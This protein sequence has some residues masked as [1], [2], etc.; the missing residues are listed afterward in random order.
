[1]RKIVTVFGSSIPVEGEEQY[2]IAYRLGAILAKNNF[3]VCNGGN[4]GIMEA[5]SRGA[6]ENGGKAIGIT[7]D[8]YFNSHNKYLTEHIICKT[9]FERINKL[10]NTGNAYIALQGGTGTLIE[11]SAV[12]ELMNKEILTQK[13]FACHGKIWKPVIEVMEEQIAKEKRKNGLLKYFDKIE[14]CAEYVI[15]NSENRIRNSE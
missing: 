2:E 8:G 5:V 14:D 11:L 7:L 4:M 13:P 1:M 10:I 6:V 9:L 3:D 12:W 15:K